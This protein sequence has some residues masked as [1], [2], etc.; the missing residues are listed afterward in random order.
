MKLSSLILIGASTGGPGRIYSILESLDRNFLGTIVIAQHMNESFFES[1]VHQL[2][3]LSSLP[4]SLITSEQLIEPNHVYVCS[5]T[6]QL[7]QTGES[8][9]IEPSH[10]KD[11]SY[12]PQIDQLFSSAAFLPKRLKRLGIILTGIGEDGAIG[13]LDLFRSGG[14]CMFESEKSAIV[15]GM[16]RRANEL[17]P[18]G[19]VGDIDEIITVI[20]NFGRE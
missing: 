2:K 16:P 12:N 11:F 9:W 10:R 18:E 19:Y 8:I 17:V 14:V 7:K 13:A 15:Y 5:L 20:Q 1:F 3:T 6:S 4:V